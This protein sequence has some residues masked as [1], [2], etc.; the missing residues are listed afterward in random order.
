MA[1]RKSQ[2]GKPK[3]RTRPRYNKERGPRRDHRRELRKMRI[4]FNTGSN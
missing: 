1:Q 3:R 2:K 4:E